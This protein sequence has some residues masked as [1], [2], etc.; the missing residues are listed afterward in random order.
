MW[1]AEVEVSGAKNAALPLLFATLLTPERCVLRHVPALADI[2]TA[3]AVLRHLGARSGRPRTAEVAVQAGTISYTE[4]PSDL[5]K[6]MR[7]SFLA[8]GPLLARFGTARVSRPA[9]AR[10]APGRSTSISPASRRWAPASR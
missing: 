9:A 2:R 7:A 10:S 6:T 4:A 3:L 5:V 1:K 8:L